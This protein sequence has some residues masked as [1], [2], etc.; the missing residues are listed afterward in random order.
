VNI[1]QGY[2]KQ[3]HMVHTLKAP[4]QPISFDLDEINQRFEGAHPRE[5]LAWCINNMRQG[6]VQSTAFGVTGMVI[7]D[8]LYRD[9][10]PNPPVPV[11]FVDTLHHF[12]ET[13]D[14]VAK[15]KAH[16]NLDLYIYKNREASDRDEF[17]HQHGYALWQK[18]IHQFH[19]LTKV[20]PFQRAMDELNVKAWINGRRRDQASTRAEIPI[21]EID[22]HGRLKI[23]PLACWTRKETWKYVF[24]YGVPYNVLHDQGYASIGDEPLTTPVAHGEHERAGRWRDSDKTECGLHI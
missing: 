11:I 22:K 14:L 2:K 6:L 9:L 16:Y 24:D 12:Q 17:A 18:D 23:N 13:L 20:E 4:V 7:M 19:V 1:H 5:I 3:R 15:S 10:Q 21:F 8:M